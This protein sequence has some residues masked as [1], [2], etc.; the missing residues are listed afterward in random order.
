MT[1]LEFVPT[2]FPATGREIRVIMRD[3]EPWW[4]GRDVCAALDLRNVSQALGRLETDERDVCV[5]DTPGGE[6][7]LSV[8]SEPGLYSLIMRSDKGIARQFKRWVTREVLP[9]IR[10]K[11]QYVPDPRPAAPAAPAPFEI[12]KTFAEALLLAA[13]QAEAL[14][15]AKAAVAST[16]QDLKI[17]QARVAELVPRAEAAET[18]MEAGGNLL[19]REVAKLLNLRQKDLFLLLVDQGIL[20]RRVNETGERY[21][22]IKAQY[23]QNGWFAP[24]MYRWYGPDGTWHVTYTPYVTPKGVEMIRKLLVKLT[25]KGNNRAAKNSRPTPL[26]LVRGA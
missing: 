11:G 18:F 23:R 1:D 20:F 4:V 15:L 12:P 2:I 5:A 10:R 22:D 19:V 7:R 13:Q 9:E 14:D 8:I 25:D 24:K 3:G 16:Q 21:Y 6:Q 26:A 17:E